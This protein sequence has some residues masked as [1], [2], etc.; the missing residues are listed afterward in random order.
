MARAFRDRDAPD[1]AD[2]LAEVHM[3]NPYSGKPSFAFWQQSVVDVGRD[4]V[5]PVV[6]APFTIGRSEAIAT[7]GSCFAQ[8]IAR[9]LASSGFN[10][11]VTETGPMT[12]GAVDEGYGL[13]SARFG[14]LYTVRQLLQLFDRAYGLFEPQ[15]TAWKDRCSE[16]FVDP[17][18]PNIQVGGFATIE[19]LEADRD[20][21]LA[22]VR[23]M[24][25]DCHIF[26]FTLGLTEG[27]ASKADGAVFPLAPGVG[28]IPSRA[29][30][31]YEPI[32]FKVGSMVADMTEFLEKLRTVN[33]SVKVILTVSPVP[34]IATFEERH[35]VVSTAASKAALR[36]VADEVTEAFDFVSYFPSY[37]IV[38]A[39]YN[40]DAFE[41]DQRSV[42]PETVAKV[43]GLFSKHYLS[44]T[45]NEIDQATV[46]APPAVISQQ[47]LERM[48][49]IDG[50]ICDEELI[51]RELAE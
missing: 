41:Y 12:A 19:A 27:W 3:K 18:R 7:A 40:N 42:K 51:V 39:H 13:F 1:M 35:V 16:N 28:G 46:T 33:P 5:D 38:T 29:A 45:K 36:V 44:G 4:A 9:T 14:N 6:S 30:T 15:D 26:I 25:E 31:D 22:A 17:F 49:E 11:F 32:N 43:M 34:L 37:E 48:E 8:H 23:R 10:Y 24:F 47:E 20:V 2:A 50:V 21:H